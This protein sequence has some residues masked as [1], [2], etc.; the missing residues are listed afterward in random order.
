MNRP[1]GIQPSDTLVIKTP[2]TTI[3]AAEIT[4]M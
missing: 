1:A 2:I 3:A 4:G